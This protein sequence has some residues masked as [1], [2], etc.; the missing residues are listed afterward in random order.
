M[1]TDLHT[2]SGA[3]ALHALSSEEAE[4]FQKHL[5]ACAACRLE[6]AELQRAAAVMGASEALAPP[7]E[8]RARVLA[9]ADRTPQQPPRPTS[10]ADLGRRRR[11]TTILSAAAAVVVI[12]AGAVVLDQV[13]DE[14]TPG[15]LLA[16]GVVRVFEAEDANTA[17]METSNGGKISVATSPELNEM[18]IDTDELPVLDDEHVYQLWAIHDD[19]V[20]SVTVLAPE[21]GA[22]MEMPSSDTEVAITIEPAGGSEQPTTEP[23]MRAKPS[24]V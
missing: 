20:E 15:G 16:S 1:S 10:A 11:I 4:E 3:Y 14:E 8:L 2:L 24:E 12:V 19:V 18:A 23:I 17:T 9:A 21:K 22:S 5:A 7:A 6:V 13:Q